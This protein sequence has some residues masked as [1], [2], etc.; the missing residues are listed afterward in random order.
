MAVT[1]IQREVEEQEKELA[2]ESAPE[3][4]GRPNVEAGPTS[5]DT[6]EMLPPW[7]HV[8]SIRPRAELLLLV[9][10]IGVL[11]LIN[12]HRQVMEVN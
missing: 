10:I 12:T 11:W 7:L 5:H 8:Q 9:S 2:G 1:Q 4:D 6:P 3:D